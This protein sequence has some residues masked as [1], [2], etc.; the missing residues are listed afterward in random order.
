[1]TGDHGRGDGWWAQCSGLA[2]TVA[3]VTGGAGAWARRVDTLGNVVGG[4]FR[5]PFLTTTP[6]GR[7]SLLCTNLHH[8][9]R[10]CSL[11]APRMQAGGRGGRLNGVAIP[12]PRQL[13]PRSRSHTSL[14]ISLR[15]WDEGKWPKNRP[16]RPRS[17][18]VVDGSDSWCRCCLGR[19]GCSWLAG[20]AMTGGRTGRR[21]DGQ[22]RTGRHG[23]AGTD[24]VLGAK[25]PGHRGRPGRRARP[26]PGGPRCQPGGTGQSAGRT[27]ACRPGTSG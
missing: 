14:R 20:L 9:L 27:T 2:G 11:A 16:L 18:C 1:V 17:T 13:D 23:R 15:M 22:A 7:D 4:T 3:V 5:P 21:A 24:G 19:A 26:G 25:E 10:A 12:S 6:N 8:V